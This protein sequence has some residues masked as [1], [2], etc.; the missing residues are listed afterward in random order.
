MVLYSSSSEVEL[1]FCLK[2]SD[3]I[4]F[5]VLHQHGLGLSTLALARAL[6]SWLWLWLAGDW[7][8]SYVSYTALFCVSDGYY[9]SSLAA[10]FLYSNVYELLI[11]VPVLV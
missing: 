6:G 10:V 3:L 5:L 2:S 11:F 8:S 7:Y 4:Y 1:D 9:S